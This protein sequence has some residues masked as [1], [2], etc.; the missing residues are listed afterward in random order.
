MK[1]SIHPVS[2]TYAVALRVDMNIAG[3]AVNGAQNHGVDQANNRSAL[4]QFFELGEADLL[5][6]VPVIG[7][8]YFIGVD[9]P[10][11]RSNQLAHIV[12]HAERA[13]K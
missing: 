1:Y 9:A 6:F 13:E 5:L 7:D 10:D 12:V 3:A 8:L 4:T 2:N 11:G